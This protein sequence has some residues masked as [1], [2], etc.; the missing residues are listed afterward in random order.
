MVPSYGTKNLCGTESMKKVKNIYFLEDG[1]EFVKEAVNYGATGLVL[2]MEDGSIVT[3]H[4]VDS[5][6]PYTQQKKIKSLANLIKQVHEY[7]GGVIK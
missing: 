1:E 5:L 4:T 7:G 3:E 6:Q 2:E